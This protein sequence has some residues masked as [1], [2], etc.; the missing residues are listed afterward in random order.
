MRP[1]ILGILNDTSINHWAISRGVFVS[2]CICVRPIHRAQGRNQ[3]RVKVKVS[4]MDIGSLYYIQQPSRRV[5]RLELRS[6]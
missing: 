1:G 6:T 3:V 4:R 2:V 5:K